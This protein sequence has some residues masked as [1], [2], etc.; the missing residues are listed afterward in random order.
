MTE[1]KRSIKINAPVEKVFQHASDYIKWSEWYEGVINFKPITDKTRG[2]G[3]KY[4]YKA[5]LFGIYATVGTEITEFKE[6]EGWIGTSFEGFGHKT[7]WIF[8]KSNGATEFTHGLTYKVPW[9]MGGKFS[10]NKF[11]QPAWIKFVE[12]SLQNLKRIMEENNMGER[13]FL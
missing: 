6:N 2:N 3:T 12:N 9:Y 11:L 4:V 8:K 7:E 5:K 10:D 13:V 1:I